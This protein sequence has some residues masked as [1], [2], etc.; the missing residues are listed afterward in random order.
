MPRPQEGSST[1]L[2]WHFTRFSSSRTA[3][4]FH[5]RTGYV[6]SERQ[7]SSTSTRVSSLSAV[8]VDTC[9][10]RLP[11]R[12][13]DA[14]ALAQLAAAM[15]SASGTVPSRG[16]MSRGNSSGRAAAL[17]SSWRS[18]KLAVQRPSGRVQQS[19][20]HY[21]SQGR[22]LCEIATLLG[23]G[24]STS[25]RWRSQSRGARCPVIDVLRVG[26][27]RASHRRSPLQQHLE[28]RRVPEPAYQAQSP[29]R[30]PCQARGGGHS[31]RRGGADERS[32]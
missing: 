22:C 16:W 3:R 23:E 21:Q 31:L 13:S 15:I 27:A 9:G 11:R 25:L 29:L 10:V 18:S 2:P 19:G 24:P 8:H 20:A 7:N 17:A 4:L 14:D 1:K 5:E 30:D 6:R 12:Q 32:R 26:A 28:T